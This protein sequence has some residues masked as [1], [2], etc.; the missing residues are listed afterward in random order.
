MCCIFII[1]IQILKQM[2][3]F[4][5]KY[6]KYYLSRYIS[7]KNTKKEGLPYLRDKLFI[8]ILLIMLPLGLIAYIP[9]F[10]ITVVTNEFVIAIINS[11]TIIIVAWIFFNK[12]ASI[13]TK[14]IVFLIILYILSTTLMIYLGTRGPGMILLLCISILITL[15]HSKRGGLISVIINTIIYFSLIIVLSSGIIYHSNFFEFNIDSWIVIGV[16][17]LV[18]NL[19]IVLAVSFL[20]DHLQE[21]F[22]IE[23]DLIDQLK[24]SSVDLVAAKQKSEES[25]KLK[26]AFLAN[27]SHEIR[28][29]MNGILGFAELLKEPGLS[30]EEQQEYIRIIEKGGKRMLNI[31]NNI[32]SISKIESG[33]MEISIQESNMNNQIQFIYSFFK[34]QIEKKGI[35]FLFRDSLPANEAILKTDREKFYAILTNLVNNAVKYTKSGFIEIGYSRQDNFLE[36]YVKDTGIGIPKDR[37]SAIFERF[38][39]ADISDKMALQGAGLGLAISKAYVNMLGGNIWVESEEG[40]GSTFYFTL[41]Y[42]HGSDEKFTP[43]NFTAD[44]NVGYDIRKLKILIAEDDEASEILISKIVKQF[45]LEVFKAKTGK[46]AVEICRKISD[47]DLILMDIQMPILNGYEAAQQIRTFNTEVIIIAQT[48][49]G[50]TG[51]SE[52]S[53]EAGCNDYISK[54]I[55]KDKLLELIHKYFKK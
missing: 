35:Q 10:Y 29:P 41:P 54:P 38:I 6:E 47:I 44:K 48:A 28:T 14:K 20:I 15:I 16:N 2:I 52:K 17:L 50:L 11:L 22:L 12:S 25:D 3:A 7:E 4:W 55:S 36:F 31:I 42:D 26:S 1:F 19:S 5:T 34:P 21:S 46:Q 53:L 13:A 49:F 9:S 37:K 18:F 27:M 40:V 30:G 24:M 39:Q 45:S 8:S 43:Q 51:D 32:V 33:Q 23:K